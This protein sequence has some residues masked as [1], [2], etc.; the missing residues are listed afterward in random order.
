VLADPTSEGL[1]GVDKDG[2]LIVSPLSAEQIPAEGEALAQAVAARVPQI[3]LPALLIE[4]DRDTRFSEA[5]TD[6]GGAQPRNPDLNPQPVRLGARLRLLMRTG[7]ALVEEFTKLILRNKPRA[8]TAPSPL[9]GCL[10]A[11]PGWTEPPPPERAAFH[12]ALFGWHPA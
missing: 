11:P 5:F 12:K 10:P 2:D 8:A 6:A 3:H 9:L 4:V 7:L 1:A